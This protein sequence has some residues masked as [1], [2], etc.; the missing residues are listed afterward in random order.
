MD[1]KT[2][3]KAYLCGDMLHKAQFEYRKKQKEELEKIEGILVYNPSSNENINSKKEA[4]SFKLAER[5]VEQDTQAIEESDIYIIDLPTADA[6]GRGSIT[7]LGQI[8]QMKRQAQITIDR[9]EEFLGIN[10]HDVED[11]TIK[12]VEILKNEIKEQQKI[13]DR[14]VFIFCDDIRWSTSDMN[15][16][17]DRVPY[18]FNAY[19]YG[20]ALSLTDG[21]GVISWE[22][23]LGELEKL[24]ASNV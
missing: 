11:N 6:G 24:G 13:I 22:E 19:N 12:T 7:E 4:D 2:Y 14:P 8:Y 17:M 10:Y 9:L 5:I 23:V 21:K 18:S 15:D 16:H 1:L 3:K 20:V